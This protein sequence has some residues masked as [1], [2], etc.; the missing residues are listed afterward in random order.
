MSSKANH[1]WGSL[2]HLIPNSTL[3]FC[4]DRHTISHTDSHTDS[5]TNRQTHT[6]TTKTIPALPA[7][8]LHTGIVI[9][10]SLVHY[11]EAGEWPMW[12]ACQAVSLCDFDHP[13]VAIY[14]S[15][16]FAITRTSRSIIRCYWTTRLHGIIYLC[17]WVWANKGHSSRYLTSHCRSTQPGH[18]VVGRHNEYQPK[19][20]DALRP[21]SK[22]R[23]GSCVG[24]R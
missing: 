12:M 1:F 10:I 9:I 22:G 2:W 19:S 21:R 7:A 3:L 11:K 6:N 5:H 18:P 4:L 20:G 23:Y 13:K 15:C 8:S 16:E 24:D 17:M 14:R